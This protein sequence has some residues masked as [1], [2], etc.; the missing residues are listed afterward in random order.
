MYIYNGAHY[1]VHVQYVLPLVWD[2]YTMKA[3]K[4]NT[5]VIRFNV[6]ID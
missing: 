2:G 4:E 5:V 6:G 3:W 1:S